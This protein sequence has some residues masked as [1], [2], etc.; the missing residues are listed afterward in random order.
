MNATATLPRVTEPLGAMLAH[1]ADRIASIT[2]T[3]GE[4]LFLTDGTRRLV[5]VGPDWMLF[6]TGY[7]EGEHSS[8][9][10]LAAVAIVAL[11]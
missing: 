1:D 4:Q 6:R 9:V 10:R 3:T 2:L 11:R 5:E 8:Y 7:G